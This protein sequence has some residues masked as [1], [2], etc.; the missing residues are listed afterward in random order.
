MSN[1]QPSSKKTIQIIPIQNKVSEQIVISSE[2]QLQSELDQLKAAQDR[3]ELIK[4]QQ[5]DLIANTEQEI[6]S[7]KEAWQQE[8]LELIEQARQ[9]GFQA[10]FEQGKVESLEQYHHLIEQANGIIEASK[11]DYQSTVE[12]SEETIL[13]LA[14]HVAKKIIKQE[15]DKEPDLFLPIVKDAISTIKDQREVTIYLHPENYE[16]ILSQKNELEKILESKATLSIYI[17]EA[18]EVGSCVIEHPFG[19]IDASIHT[20]LS[21]IYEVLHEVLLEQ[22]A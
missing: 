1:T 21:K 22:K 6:Q 20:Q 12:K 11:L 19:K 18:L 8:K 14:V 13:T 5:E 16:Y 17:N 10:G 7:A 2:E 3:L 15:I 9:E 4:I